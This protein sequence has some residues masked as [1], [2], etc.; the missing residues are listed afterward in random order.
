MYGTPWS[1]V[2]PSANGGKFI[3]PKL[4]ELTTGASKLKMAVAVPTLA[5]TVIIILRE[6][7]MAGLGLQ[8]NAVIEVHDVD[9]HVASVAC[10]VSWVVGVLSVGPKLTPHNVSDPP[11]VMG[12]LTGRP[13]RTG[14]SYEN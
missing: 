1:V 6:S 10:V 8:S 12:R 5:D 9:R 7:T 11:L 13:D 2:E 3:A 14:A 4:A